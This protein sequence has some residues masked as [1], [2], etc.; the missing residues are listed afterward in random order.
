ML[1]PSSKR[2]AVLGIDCDKAMVKRLVEMYAVGAD[3]EITFGDDVWLRA[4]VIKHEPPGVWVVD[5]NGRFWFVTNTR[6]IRAN[7]AADL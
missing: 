3:V 7:P 5:V 2:C 1:L 4:R 6:R